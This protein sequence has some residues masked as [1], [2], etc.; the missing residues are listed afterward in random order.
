M[1]NLH[2]HNQ[3]KDTAE[4]KDS[5]DKT[6]RFYMRDDLPPDA[7]ERVLGF[8][9]LVVKIANNEFVCQECLEK[10]QM[11]GIQGFTL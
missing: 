10:H 1:N 5:F 2:E 7:K 3:I 8:V 6:I 11:T 4:S 9:D